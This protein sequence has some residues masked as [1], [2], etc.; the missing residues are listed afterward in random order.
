[1]H[2]NRKFTV[3]EKRAKL[4]INIDEI[5]EI[6]HDSNQIL[7][8]TH[9]NPDGDGL[10][11]QI[12]MYNY[13]KNLN[14]DCR[15][16]NISQLPEKYQF[17]NLNNEFESF[18]KSHLD[19]INKSDLTI[20]FDIGHSIRVGKMYEHIFKNKKSI[21][22]DHHP[23]KEN[24]PFT[25]TWIDI[26][27]PATGLMVWKFLTNGNTEK[28]LDSQSAT[29]L[30]TALVTDTG[31]FRY[32]NTTSQSHE[33]AAH[34][35]E[36][37]VKPQEV[38]T[39]VYESRKL[40]DIQLLGDALN[41]MQF[42]QDK[43]VAWVKMTNDMFNARNATSNDI[44]GFADFVR[45]IENVEIAFTLV[46]DEQNDIKISFRSQGN[47]IVNDIAKKFGGGGH[48]YAAGAKAS[49]YSMTALENEILSLIE[50]KF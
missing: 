8:T 11:S 16:I 31:S 15:I 14:I 12:A 17:L 23:M 35:I 27:A 25:H 43:R 48:K 49:S 33:M 32:S 10:G 47:F 5:H 38:T 42:A 40:L 37:G 21:S 39:H 4:Q 50:R 44:E 2:L 24:E 29:G 30:Y 45:S 28:L 19:W 41:G 46:E 36:S 1:M 13:I 3:L 20:V 7:L 22:V 6:I 26:S 18:D 34:L 9:E